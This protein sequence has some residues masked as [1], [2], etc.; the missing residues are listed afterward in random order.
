MQ[1][2]AK[3]YHVNIGRC[4]WNAVKTIGQLVLHCNAL[5]TLQRLYML[6]TVF[7]ATRRERKRSLR[8]TIPLSKKELVIVYGP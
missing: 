3:G 8:D 6:V 5:E 2:V 1:S 4:C 7:G